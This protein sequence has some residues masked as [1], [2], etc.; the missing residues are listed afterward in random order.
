MRLYQRLYRTILL[1]AGSLCAVHMTAAASTSAVKVDIPTEDRPNILF[2]VIEDTS[3]YLL[4]AYGNS[5]I[6]TPNIDFLAENG[7]VF[8]NVF[9]NAPYCSPARSSLI[10][11]SY[12]TTYGTD[13]HRNNMIVPQEY[14]FPQYLKEAGY[15]T[16][17]AGKTDYNI[18]KAVQKEFYPK[19]WDGLSGYRSDDGQKPNASYNNAK[20]GDKPFFAQFNNHTTH[21]SRMTSVTVEAREASR[22]DLN[23]LQLPPHLPDLPEVRADYALHLEGVE[24][25]DAWV[26]SFLDDLR[27]RDLLDNTIIFFFSD[28]GGCLPRGKAF[29]FESG[30]KPGLIVYAP[31]K[32]QH[33]LPGS[34]GTHS[35]QLVEFVDFGPTLISLAGAELPDHLQGKPF[36]GPAAIKRKYAHAFRTNSEDHFD[37]S[38]VVADEQYF[39]LKNYTPYKRHGLKQSFQWGMPA[40]QAWDDYFYQGGAIDPFRSYYEVKA[41]EYLFD[42]SRDPSGIVNLADSPEH[43]SKLQELRAET[44]RHIQESGDLGFFPRDIRDAFTDEGISLYEW[45]KNSDY[46]LAE[47][48]RL[49]EKSAAPTQ[50]DLPDLLSYLQHERPE[51][52]WWAYSGIAYL[53]SQSELH[54]DTSGLLTAAK[55]ETLG[56][57]QA[58]AGEALVYLGQKEGLELLISSCQSGNTFAGSSLE[59]IGDLA[60]PAVEEI[61]DLASSAKSNRIR[62]QARSILIDFGMMDMEE[63]YGAQDIEGFLKG[64]FHRVSH[65]SPTLP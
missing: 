38:R 31:E 64:H 22:L 30:M 10:A 8:D 49:V 50:K 26:G 42:M 29:P 24:D 58:I 62:F 60:L 19:T 3:P 65:P 21:M 1:L 47:L 18:T 40:Q 53:A 16:V 34:P 54:L 35:R 6:S 17:N 20:R 9:S 25:A 28:H 2:L 61:K 57:L 52:R 12:A 11:G 36:M 23:A 4:P 55:E 56:S 46:P 51:F 13:W 15:Y 43:Q 14:F 27:E 5:A 45:V 32:W 63:L 48:H 39:Y 59:N 7:L 41:Q 37:P 33:L 44:A